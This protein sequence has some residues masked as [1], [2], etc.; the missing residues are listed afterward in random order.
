MTAACMPLAQRLSPLT[1][2]RT[3]ESSTMLAMATISW[4]ATA[5]INSQRRHLYVLFCELVKTVLPR[6][7]I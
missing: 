4:I 7:G 2:M 3:A 6:S 5:L 1:T